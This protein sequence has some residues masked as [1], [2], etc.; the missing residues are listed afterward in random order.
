[1]ILLVLILFYLYLF[2]KYLIQKEAKKAPALTPKEKKL[3]KQEKKAKK[4]Y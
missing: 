4:D 1:L 2:N 3:A